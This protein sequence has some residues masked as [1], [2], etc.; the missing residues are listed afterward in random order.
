MV[1]RA[2]A[3]PARTSRRD[4]G[5]QRDRAAPDSPA[6]PGLGGAAAEMGV[7]LSWA[8][9]IESMT[10]PCSSG[11]RLG[12][13]AVQMAEALVEG[14]HH[15]CDGALAREWP[16]VCAEE[17]DTCVAGVGKALAEGSFR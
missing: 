9:V 13:L 7:G 11:S 17:F 16:R 4:G 12:G 2:M 5:G 1:T 3:A 15:S 10:Q 8:R 14:A 6:A